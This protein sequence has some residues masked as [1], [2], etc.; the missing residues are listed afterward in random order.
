[1]GRLLSSGRAVTSVRLIME[2]DGLDGQR[3]L[4]QSRRER[5]DQGRDSDIKRNQEDMGGR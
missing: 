4:W 2:M 3:L 1:M 5:T